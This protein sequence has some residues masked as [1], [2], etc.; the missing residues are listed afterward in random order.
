[1]IKRREH[2]NRINK[3]FQIVKKKEKTQIMSKCPIPAPKT[4]TIK[5]KKN[6]FQILKSF[7]KRGRNWTFGHSYGDCLIYIVGLCCFFRFSSFSLQDK[8]Q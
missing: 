8:V 2:I 5:I 4:Q 1:M 6:K 7:Q 3:M